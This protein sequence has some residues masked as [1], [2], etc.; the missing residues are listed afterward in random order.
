M[1]QNVVGFESSDCCLKF[2][3]IL[4]ELNYTYTEFILTPSQFGTPNSRPRYYLL[5]SLQRVDTD[6]GVQRTHDSPLWQ[7]VA[8]GAP[9]EQE[10]G[11]QE[12]EAG[13]P[14]ASILYHLPAPLSSAQASSESEKSDDSGTLTSHESHTRSI[15]EFLEPPSFDVRLHATPHHI[16]SYHTVPYHPLSS[17]FT[18]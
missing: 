13:R 10:Q 12:Q 17:L 14:R 5:A 7:R 9:R 15:S 6:T 11:Q 4:A 16:I 1:L 8:R 18:A 2:L 3:H